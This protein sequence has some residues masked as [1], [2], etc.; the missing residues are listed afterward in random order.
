MNRGDIDEGESEVEPVAEPA[1]TAPSRGRRGRRGGGG[2]TTASR[3]AAHQGG[4]TAKSKR[5]P[6]QRSTE[7]I[8]SDMEIDGEDTARGRDAGKAKE[9][10]GM[11][12]GIQGIVL[13]PG[14]TVTTC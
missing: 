3:S 8:E 4:S 5:K 9:V 7:D 13:R 6:S 10:Q 11:S 1:D 14:T 2:R 12:T